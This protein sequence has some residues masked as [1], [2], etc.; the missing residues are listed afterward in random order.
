MRLSSTVLDVEPS[1]EGPVI[2]IVGTAADGLVENRLVDIFRKGQFLGVAAIRQVHDPLSEALVM[3]SATR[4]M[5]EVGDAV[6][7]RLRPGQPPKPLTA[8][9]FKVAGD[10]CLL[11]AGESDGVQPNEKFVVSGPVPGNPG[12]M[13]EVAELTVETV[14]VDYAGARIRPLVGG[15]DAC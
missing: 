5:P 13:R 11:A 12:A 14:K 9:V 4:S 2:T 7:V 1:R 8:V 15:R 6:L 3:E 10:Y